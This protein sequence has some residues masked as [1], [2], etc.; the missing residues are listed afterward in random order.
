[1]SEQKEYEYN[2]CQVASDFISSRLKVGN[3]YVSG[4]SYVILDDG[5]QVCAYCGKPMKLIPKENTSGLQTVCS[6]G[7]I[8]SKNELEQIKKVDEAEEELKS[9]LDK[10]KQIQVDISNKA[11]K[12]GTI[13][14]IK[15]YF[16]NKKRHDKEH[17]S[18]EKELKDKLKKAYKN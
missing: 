12:K 17:S 5:S 8:D 4:T 10:I 18:F 1:M 2:A 14:I 15:D 13:L 3:A 9:T 16:E 11:T 6:E 7:C